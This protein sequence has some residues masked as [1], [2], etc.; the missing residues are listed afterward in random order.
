MTVASERFDRWVFT[1]VALHGALFALVIFLPIVFPGSTDSWGTETGGSGGIHVEIVGSVSGVALPAPEVTREDAVANESPGFYKSEEAP[2]AP[3]P[4]KPELIPDPKVAEKK[5]P[6]PAPPKPAAAPKSA[7][8]PPPAPSNAVPFGEGGKPAL[9]YGQFTT[10]AGS[11]GVGFGD[12]VFGEKYGY[13][14]DAMTRRISQNWL[15]SLVDSRVQRAPRVYL[16]FQIARD[17]TISDVEVKQ[18]SGIPTLDRSAQRAILASNPLQPLPGDYRG[19]TVDV[20]FYFE[21]SR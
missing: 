4:D 12:G 18:S 15:Q 20:T 19:S 16:S 3:P 8:P 1:S 13:Y 2:P 21:Y 9:A 11:A 7:T 14:V 6:P 5:P 17:G 10:G